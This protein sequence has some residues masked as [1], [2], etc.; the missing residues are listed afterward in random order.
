MSITISLD[1]SV[2][3]VADGPY[4]LTGTGVD[5]IGSF[6]L[7]GTVN[8]DNEFDVTK[9]YTVNGKTWSW[10]YQAL[11]DESGSIGGIW[12][13]LGDDAATPRGSFQLA[14][15]ENLPIATARSIIPQSRTI[16]S[17][18]STPTVQSAVKALESK[19]TKVPAAALQALLT[20]F[21]S[22]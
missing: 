20:G 21:T 16:T 4:A 7:K 12:R 18:T 10:R 14:R 1:G 13:E 9:T 3:Y 11:F 22:I 15:Q 2:S 6:T 19:G 17:A 5:G 8:K